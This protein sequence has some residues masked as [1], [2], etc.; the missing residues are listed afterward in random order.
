MASMVKGCLSLTV[1]TTLRRN[2]MES[3]SRDQCRSARLTVKNR[4][5]QQ[6]AHAGIALHSSGFRT[7]CG[8]VAP[9]SSPQLGF[10]AWCRRLWLSY[11]K[12][13]IAA[14]WFFLL[15]FVLHPTL[16]EVR[17]TGKAGGLKDLEPLKAAY[18]TDLLTTIRWSSCRL[19]LW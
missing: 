4:C 1:A 14:P 17:T 16:A 19:Y 10:T 9:R 11:A 5:H 7:E 8:N 6:N 12:P 2:S 3:T 15:G 18:S 13:N